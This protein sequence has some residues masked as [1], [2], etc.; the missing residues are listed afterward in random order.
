MIFARPVASAAACACACAGGSALGDQRLTNGRAEELPQLLP[1]EENAGIENLIIGSDGRRWNQASASRLTRC[2]DPLW[3]NLPGVGEVR[4]ERCVVGRRRGDRLLLSDHQDA[5]DAG[6]DSVEFAC[7]M[8]SAESSAAFRGVVRDRRRLRLN[9][10]LQRADAAERRAG[11]DESGIRR[12]RRGADHTRDVGDRMQSDPR[13]P[14]PLLAICQY[15]LRQEITEDLHRHPGRVRIALHAIAL[16][17]W[18][19]RRLG[20]VGVY[21]IRHAQRGVRRRQPVAG[22]RPT[23]P[24]DGPLDNATKAALLL[25]VLI[26]QRTRPNRRQRRERPGQ[27]GRQTVAA[28]PSKLR[29]ARREATPN[30]WEVGYKGFLSQRVSLEADA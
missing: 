17:P 4:A 1:I 15:R 10:R 25:G 11:R 19:G 29:T 30:T 5:P 8:G 22:D 26:L 21:R 9:D 20:G 13:R 23:Q 27:S 18:C 12:R 2:R 7:R 28:A 3:P 16:H 14:V 6:I 24:V